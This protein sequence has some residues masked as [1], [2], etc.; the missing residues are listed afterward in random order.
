MPKNTST[1]EERQLVKLLEKAHLPEEKKE[2][3]LERIRNGEMSEDL[4]E[5]IRTSM[6]SQNEGDA[7]ERAQANRARF[8]ADLAM[9]VRRWRLSSQANNFRRR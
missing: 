1:Q 4:A 6:A 5:E 8:L 7:D 2:P 9:I 3:W